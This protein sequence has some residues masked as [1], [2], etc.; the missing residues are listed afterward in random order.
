MNNLD[1]MNLV[2]LLAV[3]AG[4]AGAILAVTGAYMSITQLAASKR[5]DAARWALAIPAG[6]ITAYLSFILY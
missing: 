6:S 5:R 4:L 1:L 2:H 3:T